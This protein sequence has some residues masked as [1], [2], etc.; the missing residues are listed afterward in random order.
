VQ[1]N[2]VAYLLSKDADANDQDK[3]GSTPL[4]LAAR[5]G[6]TA[7][8]KALLADGAQDMANRAGKTPSQVAIDHDMEQLITQATVRAG[9]AGHA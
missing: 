1:L 4:H 6:F 5:C 9:A 7:V 8:A 2:I 3:Q